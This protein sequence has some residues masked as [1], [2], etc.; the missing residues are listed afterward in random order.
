[1]RKIKKMVASFLSIMFK[2][3]GSGENIHGSIIPEEP[4]S[5]SAINNGLRS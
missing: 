2:K 5:G 3:N 4:G 1:M